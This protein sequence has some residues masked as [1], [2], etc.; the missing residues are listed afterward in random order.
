MR[1]NI[2]QQKSLDKYA[3]LC[4][5]QLPNQNPAQASVTCQYAGVMV[6]LSTAQFHSPVHAVK[7][8]LN[9]RF[10]SRQLVTLK[11][12]RNCWHSNRPRLSATH[13]LLV[14]KFHSFTYHLHVAE[15]LFAENL[16][17]PTQSTH[18]TYR[19]TLDLE[20]HNGNHDESEIRQISC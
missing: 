12:V 3:R 14:L 17:A 4:H 15:E 16:E 5:K 18:L 7:F 19:G 10:S 20:R 8:T 2:H 13:D 11:N 9:P 1:A 6:A